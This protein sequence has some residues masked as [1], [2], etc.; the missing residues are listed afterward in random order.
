L[1]FKAILEGKRFLAKDLNKQDRK[2]PFTCSI[3]GG[4]LIPRMGDIKIWHF[5]HKE[6]GN[7]NSE[8]ETEEHSKM[9]YYFLEVFEQSGCKTDIEVGIKSNDKLH[10]ADVV[11]YEDN[12]HTPLV[13]GVVIECQCSILP[14]EEIADR[15][16]H[17]LNNGLIPLWV[18][19]ENY[20]ERILGKSVLLSVEKYLME[21][22][23]ILFIF[24]DNKIFAI[25][26]EKTQT[27]LSP[28]VLLKAALRQINNMSWMPLEIQIE[29]KLT[30]KNGIRFH[31][32]M[33]EIIKPLKEIQTF[34]L[35]MLEI[36]SLEEIARLS[37]N[38]FYSNY[39]ELYFILKSLSTKYI[40]KVYQFQ[41]QCWKCNKQIDVVWEGVLRGTSYIDSSPPEL[42]PKYPYLKEVYSK[43][44]EK[45]VIG[46]TCPYCR[47]YQGNFFMRSTF[48]S[49]LY[50]KN[51]KVIDS[52]VNK[53]YSE[54]LQSIF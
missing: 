13:K 17:Y 30:F 19:G 12:F 50:E 31:Q 43:T 5:A 6:H 9:K 33:G 4:Q 28:E 37:N 44:M 8:P 22:F 41:I 49:Y 36:H 10:E 3:C 23:G 46:N 20:I 45:N 1:T 26:N 39:E 53:D 27:E 47:A 24:K 40:S 51:K 38:A 48:L 15:N 7:H 35:E 42:S 32:K 34:L 29:S 11:V 54:D 52:F 2:K 16:Y 14:Y 21:I 25:D 18:L